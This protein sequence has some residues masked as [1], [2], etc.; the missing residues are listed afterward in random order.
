MLVA[1]GC[2]QVIIVV[3]QVYAGHIG[4]TKLAAVAL[5]NTLWTLVGPGDSVFFK[6]RSA[7]N[8]R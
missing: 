4:T 7:G 5:G 6:Y 1:A 8:S 3:S 2:P